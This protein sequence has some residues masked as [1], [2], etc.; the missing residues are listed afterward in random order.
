[1]PKT[2]ARKKST[3]HHTRAASTARNRQNV[4]HRVTNSTN[5]SGEG[6]GSATRTTSVNARQERGGYQGL[7]MP[8]M[9]VLGCWGLAILFIFFASYPDH[10]LYGGI[11]VLMA[12]MWSLSFGLRLRRIRQAQR[13]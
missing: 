6:S 3:G 12:L 1:M 11:A 9:V 13:K 2:K 7:I 5:V 4:P 8:G 10:I